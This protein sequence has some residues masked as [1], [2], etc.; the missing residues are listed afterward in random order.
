M[1]VS[2]QASNCNTSPLGVPKIGGGSLIAEAEAVPSHLYCRFYLNYLKT[3]TKL[4]RHA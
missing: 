3:F 1:C 2:A 4:D